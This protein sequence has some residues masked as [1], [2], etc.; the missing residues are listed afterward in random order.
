MSNLSDQIM[1]DIK[2]AM[3]AKDTVALTVLRALKSAIKYAAIEQGGADAVLNETDS[4]AVIRKQI[5]QRQDSIQSYKEGGRQD[6]ADSEAAEIAV[7]EKYLPA[8]LSDDE[9]T[10]LVDASISEIGATSKKEMGAVMKLLQEKAAGRA[11]NKILSQK[12]MEK[13]S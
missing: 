4:L 9:I 6:L 3:K 1:D 10:A 8:S 13:L 12:V 7:L 11:D 2:D 5:K